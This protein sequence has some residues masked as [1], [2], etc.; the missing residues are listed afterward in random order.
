MASSSPI[1]EVNAK[2]RYFTETERCKLEAIT[3]EKIEQ[4]D[5]ERN[6]PLA[7]TKRSGKSC[8]PDEHLSS[9]FCKKPIA[10][11][12]KEVDKSAIAQDLKL[13][14]YL[15]PDVLVHRIQAT[16]MR[17]KGI[18][19]VQCKFGFANALD[20]PEDVE[21]PSPRRV[22]LAPQKQCLLPAIEY[23]LPIE[24]GAV[25]DDEDLA[26]LGNQRE[27]DVAADPARAARGVGK[28]FPPLDHLLDEELFWDDEQ[29]SDARILGVV[30]QH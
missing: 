21:Q 13:L 24:H 15:L 12:A 16:K 22:A 29:V 1:T 5:R 30:Q 23:D 11:S 4:A 19:F 10:S 8:K 25:A 27:H 20:A 14:P 3:G 26:G 6:F 9:C 2:P 28:W 17:L 7:A 18:D